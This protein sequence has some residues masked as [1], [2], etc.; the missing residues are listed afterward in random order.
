MIAPYPLKVTLAF[1]AGMVVAASILSYIF[2]FHVEELDI[3]APTHRR[4]F[5]FNFVLSMICSLISAV[6]FLIPL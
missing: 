2:A 6:T 3:V 5:E 4:L 1:S